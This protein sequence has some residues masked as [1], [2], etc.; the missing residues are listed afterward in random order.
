MNQRP[1]PGPERRIR[2]LHVAP[3]YYPAVAFGGPIFST[4]A[5]CDSVAADPGFEV[6]VLTTDSAGPGT[7]ETLPGK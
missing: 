5:I 3:L 2:V 6:Q 4:K 7:P 1:A